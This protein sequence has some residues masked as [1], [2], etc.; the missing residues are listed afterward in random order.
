MSQGLLNLRY[1]RMRPA[2][3]APRGPCS[4][5]ER[6]HCLADIVERGAGVI[7]EHRRIRPHHPERGFITLSK[8]SSHHWHYFVVCAAQECAGL[9]ATATCT[10]QPEQF[11]ATARTFPRDI[12]IVDPRAMRISV[13]SMASE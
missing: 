6:R 12:P 10:P 13:M 11:F 5:L 8:N 9:S 7:D 1:E 2:E 4:V 3:Y